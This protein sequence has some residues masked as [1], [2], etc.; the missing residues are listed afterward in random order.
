MKH[1]VKKSYALINHFTFST[2][3]ENS[4][5]QTTESEKITFADISQLMFPEIMSAFTEVAEM[6]TKTSE[7]RAFKLIFNQTLSLCVIMESSTK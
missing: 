5:I 1:G 6:K 3:K 4:N 2:A 7:K